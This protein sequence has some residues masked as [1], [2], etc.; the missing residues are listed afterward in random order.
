MDLE[1][2]CTDINGSFL[3]S[4]I[5]LGII[6][7][8]EISSEDKDKF[9]RTF[10]K[11]YKDFARQTEQLHDF[12]KYYTEDDALEWYT[13][14]TFIY[15]LLN[16]ALRMQDIESIFLFRFFI[17]D[18]Q[19]QLK[20]HRCTDP[21]YTYRGQLMSKTELLRLKQSIGKLISMHS[22]VST[23]LDKDIALRFNGM[24]NDNTISA[25]HNLEYVL[26]EILADPTIEGGTPAFAD[27][28][29]FS[30]LDEEEILFTFGS[31]FRLNSVR[32][33]PTN[34][35]LIIV[36]MTLCSNDEHELKTVLETMKKEYQGNATADG[37][38]SKEQTLFSLSMALMNMG[39]FKSAKT[40]L[41]QILRT[42]QRDPKSI[43][44]ATCCRFIG[45]VCRQE[46][47]FKT[48]LKWYKRALKMYE[49][50]LPNDH[51]LVA[52]TYLCLGHAYS[53]T[54]DWNFP[55]WYRTDFASEYPDKK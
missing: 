41:T 55:T 19:N 31:L 16:K 54:T 35:K 15:R 20:A 17:R 34:P 40:L 39:R 46:N 37:S 25:P 45:D 4:Q 1:Q 10:A 36:S 2:S 26:F 27:I 50:I 52:T 24:V 8:S 9:V 42:L 5:I 33:D 22:F 18:L 21:V 51:V 32:E 43:D 11:R 7:E 53:K 38:D 14:D 6:L 13:K 29:D 28:R 3:F 49:G 48:S 44:A 12:N 23:S 47:R 30:E